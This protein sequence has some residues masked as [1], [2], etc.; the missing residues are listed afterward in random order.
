MVFWEGAEQMCSNIYK[1]TIF[2]CSSTARPT[3]FAGSR[4]QS[5]G[6]CGSCTDN[7]LKLK[8]WLRQGP[9]CLQSCAHSRCQEGQ[10]VTNGQSSF[11]LSFQ[12][13]LCPIKWTAHAVIMSEAGAALKWAQV[14]LV[15]A[16]I[17]RFH[18]PTSPILGAVHLFL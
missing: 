1:C 5:G 12:D 7:F 4:L 9:C 8:E 11:K 14:C 2:A 18:N 16:C 6:P 17:E 15:M 3:D 10:Q 13:S